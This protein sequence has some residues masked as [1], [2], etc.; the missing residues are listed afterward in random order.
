MKHTLL[1][2]VPFVMWCA[3]TTAQAESSDSGRSLAALLEQLNSNHTTQERIRAADALAQYEGS[4]V[5]SLIELL[6]SDNADTR[7]FACLALTRLG[8]CAEEAVADLLAI[9]SDPGDPALCTAMIALG[10]IGPAAVDAAP[11]LLH[12]AREGDW[13]VRERAVDSLA[14]IGSRAVPILLDQIRSGDSA[15]KRV[16]CDALYRM[17]TMA[18]EAVPILAS[19]AVEAADDNR[20]ASFA[21]LANIGSPARNTLIGMLQHE[22]GD[23]RRLAAKALGQMGRQGAPA[24]AALCK[25]AR[26]Q[27]AN[28]RFWAVWALGG[29]GGSGR[30]VADILLRASLDQDAD[31]RW[32]TAV[33]L[34][35]VEIGESAEQVLINLLKDPHPAVRAKAELITGSP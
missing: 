19:L 1:L 35:K 21:A 13:V 3:A 30:E 16:A 32:Q 14:K 31:V 8:P 23:V 28:V 20:D 25:A 26:D 4:A 34:Q 9:I 11:T 10:R 33:I 2:T 12:W 5:P 17:G 22:D 6:H 29:V 18:E 7:Y 24:V 15:T 27:D